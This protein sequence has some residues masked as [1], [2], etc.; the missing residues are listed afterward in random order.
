MLKKIDSRLQTKT[1]LYF[2]KDNESFCAVEHEGTLGTNLGNN[3]TEIETGLSVCVTERGNYIVTEFSDL[4]HGSTENFATSIGVECDGE[5]ILDGKTLNENFRKSVGYDCYVV[6][7][8]KKGEAVFYPIKYSENELYIQ[9]DKEKNR[10]EFI[11]VLVG[12]AKENVRNICKAGICFSDEKSFVIENATP[13][14]FNE[15]SIKTAGY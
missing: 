2:N 9:Y 14:L 7:K 8:T 13:Y 1:Y 11:S 6:L 5:I 10:I 15:C 12:K 3:G 4:Y